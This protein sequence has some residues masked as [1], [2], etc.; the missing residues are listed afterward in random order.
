MDCRWAERRPF[1][2]FFGDPAGPQPIQGPLGR[3]ERKT[4]KEQ[5][6]MPAFFTAKDRDSGR[7]KI[8]LLG[9]P[10]LKR[11]IG[12]ALDGRRVDFYA[13]VLRYQPFSL[14]SR[15]VRRDGPSR[16]GRV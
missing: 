12:P 2:S 15:R 5:N 1:L 3:V 8:E 9:D 10:L 16:C 14:S 4:L 7:S 6:F 13:Q 11:E